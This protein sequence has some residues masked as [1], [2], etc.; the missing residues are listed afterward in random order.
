MN[1]LWANMKTKRL[2]ANEEQVAISKIARRVLEVLGVKDDQGRAVYNSEDNLI[3]LEM[4]INQEIVEIGIEPAGDSKV[5]A[6]IEV[7][8]AVMVWRPGH[9][10]EYLRSLLPIAEDTARQ[11]KESVERDEQWRFEPIDDKYLFAIGEAA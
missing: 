9:W 4:S 7:N 5:V 6:V 11:R 2:R 10:I 8:Y 1:S 3:R